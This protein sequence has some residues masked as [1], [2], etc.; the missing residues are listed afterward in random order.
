M[1]TFHFNFTGLTCD[2]C[3]RLIQKRLGKIEGVQDVSVDASGAATFS[4]PREISKEEV[5]KA[6]AGTPYI[7][8]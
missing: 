7:L 6:L 2:A 3:A 5:K 8:T 1:H 4:A